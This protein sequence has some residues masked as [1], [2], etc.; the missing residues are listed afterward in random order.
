MSAGD[1]ERLPDSDSPQD[2]VDLATGK[3]PEEFEVQKKH[4]ERI[5]KAVRNQGGKISHKSHVV[6]KFIGRKIN[7]QFKKP[8]VPIK[9][10][11][12]QGEPRME[13]MNDLIDMA[14]KGQGN[15]GMGNKLKNKL[16]RGTKPH[17]RRNTRPR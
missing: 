2:E 16:S 14:R 10:R 11:R 1:H 7:P 6:D 4:I 13:S 17:G 9:G 15:I 5:R 3:P 8:S 12:G